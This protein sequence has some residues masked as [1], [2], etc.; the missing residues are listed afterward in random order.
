MKRFIISILA[1]LAAVT[2]MSAGEP[3]RLYL[4][5]EWQFRQAGEQEWHR[6]T[7]PGCVH[8][9]LMASGQID[10][11]FWSRNEKSLQW[12]GEKDWE[13]RKTFVYSGCIGNADKVWLVMEGVDTYASVS[14]NG[15]PVVC[16]GNMFRTWEVDVTDI[17]RTGENEIHVRFESVFKKDMPKYLASPYRLQAW[18][19]NDQSDI[20]LSLYARKAGYH[21][22]W[23]WGPRLITAGLW[24][25]VYL[26]KRDEWTLEDVQIKTLALDKVSHR[27]GKAAKASMEALVDIRSDIAV[28]GMLTILMDG[29]KVYGA[30]RT[31]QKGRNRLS[32]GFTLKNT[33]LWWS[34]GL[35][36]PEMSCF[37]ITFATADDMATISEKAGIRTVE[38]IRED[39]RWGKSLSVRLNGTDVFC[40][41]ANWIP[42]DNFPGRA[43]RSRYSRLVGDAAKANM[44]M[45]RVWG[46][47]LYECEDFYES[48]DSL[49]IMVWQ[50][51]TFACGMFPSDSSYLENVAA[52][53]RDNI[54]R[55][56][57]HPS[58]VLWCGNNEN[59]ISYFEWGWKR[60]LTEEQQKE[61]E[62]GMEELFHHTIPE[63]I[64]EVDDTRYYHPTSPSTGYNGIPYSMGN[65]HFWSVWK[66]GWIEEYLKPKNIARFMSEYGFISYPDMHS[67]RKFIPE[68]GMRTD[69]P[70]IL[71]HHRAYDDVTRDPEFSNKMIS[72]YLERYA[73]IPEGFEDFVH[74]TQWF[75]AEAIKV[76]IEAHRRAKP[77]CMGT[78]FWQINDCW[79]SISWSSIDYYGHWKALHHYARKAYAPVIASPYSDEDGNI[80]IKV[81]SDLHESFEGRIEAYTMNLDGSV[82]RKDGKDITLEA[83][84]CEDILTMDSGLLEGNRMLYVRLYSDNTCIGDNIYFRRFPNDYDYEVPSISKEITVTDD[85]YVIELSSDTLV[86]GLYLYTDNENDIFE[87][88]YMDLIPGFSRTVHVESDTPESEFITT[89]KFHTL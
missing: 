35:G 13:Y 49:G 48:C 4:T 6:A 60:T 39:D 68:W 57:N 86:R 7:V 79:P 87:D 1:V 23:D 34:N 8:T 20:W 12:I 65:A 88:N 67:I 37:E 30:R 22:G 9:D 75:Q 21:Y 66:G 82:I 10:D 36:K 52:E 56:R 71:A 53:I 50:D 45:L 31:V 2:E 81:I 19:N 69:S 42:I 14:I 38:I 77:Y 44:N 89:L 16:T 24:K 61:Y 54:R 25:P 58:I 74:M 47:G 72:R 83:D 63:A 41:G 43:D 55:L 73:W 85:G 28:E 64:R 84:G 80:R 78:L 70:E 3:E 15:L 62:E 27:S 17:V 46:G 59:E 33:D 11:P 26:E 29:R 51:M 32:C 18:P 5:G 40:K 76:A